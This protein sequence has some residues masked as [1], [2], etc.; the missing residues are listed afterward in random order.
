MPTRTILAGA[1]PD[2]VAGALG[3][4]V[5]ATFDLWHGWALR[6]RD[7]IMDGRP[8]IAMD[9]YDTVAQSFA[10]AGVNLVA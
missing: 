7:F 3:D 10:R 8:G 1:R 4:T 2:A 5:V 9:E 6:Q